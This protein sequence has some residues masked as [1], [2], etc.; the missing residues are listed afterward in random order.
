MRICTVNSILLIGLLGFSF[1][2]HHVR[3][4]FRNVFSK[5]WLAVEIKIFYVFIRLLDC[6]RVIVIVIVFGEYVEIRIKD[7]IEP[8]SRIYRI[9]N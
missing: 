7:L 5:F 4:Y 9:L 8:V 1:I 6:I 3:T 2:S